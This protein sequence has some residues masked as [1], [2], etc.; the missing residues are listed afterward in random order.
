MLINGGLLGTNHLRTPDGDLLLKGNVAKY[1]V[2][3]HDVL[4]DDEGDETGI[5]KEETEER[6]KSQLSVLD[7]DGELAVTE[8]TSE[9]G[10]LLEKHVGQLA[11]I[12]QARNVPQYD[13]HPHAW[14]WAV[15]EPLS[16]GRKL[17]GRG[18]E[19]GLTDMQKHLTIALGR[20]AL[21]H[22][23]AIANAEMG[24]GKTTC[25]IAAAEYIE[26]TQQKAGRPGAYP[27]LVVGP[28]IVTSKENWPKEIPEV[29]PGAQSRVITVGAKPLP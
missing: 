17:P 15:F 23:S 21:K 24:S 14:E 12:V 19:T 11:E 10:A 25:G 9:I 26:T 3:K 20:L 13:M 1:T 16:R 6:F 18:N 22:G 4:V 29:T 27:A 7:A 28:G 2:T 5:V 8:N